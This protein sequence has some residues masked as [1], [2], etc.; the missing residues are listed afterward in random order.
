MRRTRWLQN[1]PSKPK[2]EA[3]HKLCLQSIKRK[4]MWFVGGR[5][6]RNK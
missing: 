2:P 4:E 5:S 6:W 1:I 3:G